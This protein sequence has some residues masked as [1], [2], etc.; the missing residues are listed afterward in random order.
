[1]GG[2]PTNR[3]KWVEHG[4]VQRFATSHSECST[5]QPTRIERGVP[6]GTKGLDRD[7][8]QREVCAGSESIFRTR[9]SV[10]HGGKDCDM[11]LTNLYSVSGAES[12]C[13]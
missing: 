8:E 5:Q 4:H 13:F 10:V 2:T 3:A 6:V 7:V 1:M 9:N 12:N 11:M